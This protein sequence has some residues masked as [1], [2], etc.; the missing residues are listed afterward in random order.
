VQVIGALSWRVLQAARLARREWKKEPGTEAPG[1]VT[2]GV[3][4]QSGHEPLDIQNQEP[5]AQDN[6]PALAGKD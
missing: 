1:Q 6:R 4:K 3:N 5:L 2:G